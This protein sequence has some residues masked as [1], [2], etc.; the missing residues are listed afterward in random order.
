[1]E[2]PITGACQC[3]QVTYE[4]QKAPLKVL[5]CHCTECQKLSTSP[6]SVTAIVDA[7][8]IQF[9]GQL[10]EWGRLA[11]SGNRNHA[12]FCPDCGNRIYH[13][14]PDEP[15]TVKLKLKPINLQDDAVFKPQAH[16]WV[17]EKVEWF[18][19]PDDVMVFGKQP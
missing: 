3:G 14:N 12:M 6:F 15:S 18:D 11:E 17:S 13:F 5:A 8:T 4:L 19:I 10:K 16:V 2:Y 9:N 1:M 7:S